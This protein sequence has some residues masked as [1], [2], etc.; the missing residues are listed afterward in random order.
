MEKMHNTQKTILELTNLLNQ[1]EKI[2]LQAKIIVENLEEQITDL[3][4]NLFDNRINLVLD[5]NLMNVQKLELIK[6]I[7]EKCSIQDLTKFNSSL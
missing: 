3:K 2:E 7:L 4:Y 6:E 1:A 5:D